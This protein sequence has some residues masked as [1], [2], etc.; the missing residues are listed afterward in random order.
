MA[1][2][3]R[4]ILVPLDGMPLAETALPLA[5]LFADAL[6]AQ[7][8]LLRVVPADRPALAQQDAHDYL[9]DIAAVLIPLE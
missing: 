7:L 8:D 4:T 6:S 9:N 5:R 3:Q 2:T 1:L